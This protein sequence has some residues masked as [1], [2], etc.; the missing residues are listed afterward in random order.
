MTKPDNE[1][2]T[3]FIRPNSATHSL[4]VLNNCGWYNYTT[5]KWNFTLKTQ[6]AGY[7][8][9]SVSRAKVN[10]ATSPT[11]VFLNAV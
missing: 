3:K 6:S 9:T 4:L 7:A 2:R 5:I 1:F 11:W 10:G 8:E